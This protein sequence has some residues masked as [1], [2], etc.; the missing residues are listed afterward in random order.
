MIVIGV[1]VHKAQNIGS[2]GAIG[3]GAYIALAGLWGSPISRRLGEPGPRLRPRSRR[4]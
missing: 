2:F 4:A 1:D 3:V